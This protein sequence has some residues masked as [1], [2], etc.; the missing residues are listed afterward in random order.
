MLHDL[1]VEAPKQ[2]CVPE[3]PPVSQTL[4]DHRSENHI[5]S[6]IDCPALTYIPPKDAQANA[7]PL[8]WELQFYSYEGRR[9]EAL[10]IQIAPRDLRGYL[11]ANP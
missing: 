7:V 9:P 8:A 4:V 2:A 6:A 11:Y 1:L 5:A 3:I 10:P